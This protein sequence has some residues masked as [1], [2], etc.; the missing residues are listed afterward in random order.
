MASNRSLDLRMHAISPFAAIISVDWG[1]S[2]FRCRLLDAGGTI[3]DSRQSNRGVRAVEGR[4]F[5]AALLAMVG[6]WIA[7]HGGTPLLLSGMIGSRLGWVEAPYVPCPAGLPEI[8][9]ALLPLDIAGLPRAFIVPGVSYESVE[10]TDVMRGEECEILGCLGDP[11]A[12]TALYLAPGTHSKWIA[13]D[14]DRITGFITV[15]TGELFALLSSQSAL[16]EMVSGTTVDEA[17]FTEGLRLAKASLGKGGILPLLFRIR[18]DGVLGRRSPPQSRG[19]LSGMLIGSEI[20]YGLSKHPQDLEPC[21]VGDDKLADHYQRALAEGF[22]RASRRG[23]AAA[24]ALGHLAIA[25]HL[26]ITS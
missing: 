16:A 21:I 4:D 14:G 9:S 23:P 3:L 6:D 26:G 24:A 22:G 20:A 18:S 15:M 13:V 8:A 2:S 25:R 11:A 5:R 19:L 12:R 7:A 1:L 17:S 10:R